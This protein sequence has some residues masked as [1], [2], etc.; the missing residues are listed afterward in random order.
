MSKLDELIRGLCPDGVEYKT[1]GEIAVD[2]YRGAGITRDQVTAEGTPCV[3]YGEIYTTYGVWFDKCVSHTDESKLWSKKYFEHGDILFAITGESVDDI[4][5]C[6]VYI[7][8][9]KCLAGGDIVV[10]KHNQNPK[11]L[12]Y[13]LAT[14][15]AR[16]QKSKGKVKSKVV[17]SSVP[18]IREIKVPVP[19]IEVQ[20]EIVRILDNF[21]NLTTELTAELTARKT[22]YAYYRDNLLTTKPQWNHVKILD[23]LSQPIT[24]GPHTTPQFVQNGVPF[25]SVDS[26]WDGKIHFEKRRGYITEEFDEECCKKYKPQKNDVYMVK[27]GSTTG[28]VAFVDTDIRFNIWSPLAAMRVNEKNSARFLFYLLQTERV[29]KQVKAKSSHGSQ[30]NLGMRELEQFEV[31]IPPLD[32]QNRIVNVL[33]NFEKICSD[34]NIGLPAEIEARQKQYEYYRDKLLTFAETGNTILSRAEQSRAEQSRA[35]QSRALI[36]LLQYVFGYAVVSLQDVVKNSCSGGTPKKGVSEYY[37][38]G[39]IPWLRTQEVVF[40]DICKTE[41]FITES[42]VK[43]SAAKWIPENCVIVAISGAT[44]GRCAINKIPLTTNQHC[45]NLEVDPEMALYRYVY[46]CICAKQEELLAKKEGARGDLNSTRILSLQIDLPSIEKQKRIVSILDRFDA[47]CNDLTSGL[48]AEIEARQKQ[49]E[50]YR[51]KLLT[52]KEVAAT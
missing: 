30:P 11:Y 37:E 44:A 19:P 12:S 22:Q 10:L 33:D 14:T 3:R 41:C 29:Q 9:E 49:Y 47:I 48:P 20:C 7:G 43:N 34:L 24:D 36:K 17:H 28:K 5:K 1:L 16:Q 39:N 21:T 4:A 40:R 51:D 8:H 35:E 2:I 23:M 46:Y 13:A 38:D 52:F 42:A 18:A 45:L 31:D 15:D 26:I 25:I 6:C 32:V 50:Y 27:S